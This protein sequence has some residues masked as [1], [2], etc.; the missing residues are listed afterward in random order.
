MEC[1]APKRWSKYTTIHNQLYV[2][3]SKG[4]VLQIFNYNNF[5]HLNKINRDPQTGMNKSCFPAHLY[6]TLITHI[7]KLLIG[8]QDTVVLGKNGRHSFGRAQ[9]RIPSPTLSFVCSE[10]PPRRA[11]TKRS[12]LETK[13][14]R[15]RKRTKRTTL[16]REWASERARKRTRSQAFMR[17]KETRFEGCKWIERPLTHETKHF[18]REDSW[19]KKE[20][21]GGINCSIK[22][23]QSS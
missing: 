22:C 21:V 8:C 9:D 23:F 12:K 11:K 13:N 17:E 19:S 3:W 7:I 18:F 10:R 1:A 4:Q 16:M 15:A 2:I 14:R 5:R 6:F 20:W